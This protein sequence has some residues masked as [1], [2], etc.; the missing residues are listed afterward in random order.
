ML[1][2]PEWGK[3]E[4]DMHSEDPKK[5]AEAADK[6]LLEREHQTK[7]DSKIKKW[8]EDRKKDAASQKPDWKK[9][10]LK[11]QKEKAETPFKK[12]KQLGSFYGGLIPAPGYIL[13]KPEDERLQTDTGIYLP[14]TDY[15]PNIGIVRATGKP[16][17]IPNGRGKFLECPV[18]VGDRVLYKRGA[19]ADLD[20][21]GEDYL[22]MLFTDILGTFE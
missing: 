17:L 16:A 7:T 21:D 22:L 20:M 4:K 9:S 12:L 19:G 15:N 1:L 11:D 14:D 18:N 3:Y 6:F 13:V 2:K 5:A 10:Q 8:E